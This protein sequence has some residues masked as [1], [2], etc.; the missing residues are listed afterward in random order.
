MG[1][2]PGIRKRAKKRPEALYHPLPPGTHGIDPSEVKRHQRARIQGAMIQAV[3]RYGYARTTLASI[4]DLAS[5]S[6]TTFYQHFAD[7]QDCF[8]QTQDLIIELG[9]TRVSSA[10]RADGDWRERLRAGFRAFVDI[11]VSDPAA[12]RLVSVES[13]GAGPEAV[14]RHD[15]ATEAFEHLF[16]QSFDH[17]RAD[18]RVSDITIRAIVGGI[19]RVVYVHLRDGTAHELPGYVDELLDWALSYQ[20]P[21]VNVPRKP[22][23]RRA[24]AP[25]PSVADPAPPSPLDRRSLGHRERILRAVTSLVARRGY[26]VVTIPDISTEAGISNQTFYAHF[27]GKEEALLAAFNAEASDAVR[28]TGAA[29][30]TAPTWPQAIRA[31]LHALLLHLSAQPAFARLALTEMMSAGKLAQQRADQGMDAYVNFLAP[32]SGTAPHVPLVVV[33]AIIGGTWNILHHEYTHGRLDRLPT[34]TPSLTF[35][36]LAPFLGAAEA[37]AVARG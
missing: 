1:I 4:V 30:E 34:L 2:V 28:V 36:V 20:Q 14:R 5:V 23:V 11:I 19:R 22:A 35:V 31:G 18:G 7:K 24:A 32:A 26:S 13:F 6:R 8:L 17:A 16:R 21:G 10:Y 33:Q 27:T 3:T 29:F 25:A 12:A 9:L 15:A 37:A